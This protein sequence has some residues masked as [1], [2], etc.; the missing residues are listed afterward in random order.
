MRHLSPKITTHPPGFATPRHVHHVADE[1]FYVLEGAMLGFCGDRQWRVTRRG[2][3]W[4]PHG[5]PHGYTVDGD[6]T[7]RTLAFTVPA[8]LERFVAEGGAPAA[9]RTLQPPGAPDIDKLLAAGSK[10]GIEN[11]GPPQA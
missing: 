10:H 9:A 4:L 5:I 11:L 6:E 7:L 2:L 3:V 1:G 8:G